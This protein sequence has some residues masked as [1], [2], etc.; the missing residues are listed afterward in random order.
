MKV[1]DTVLIK[2]GSH[3]GMVMRIVD[4]VDMPEGKVSARLDGINMTYPLSW[5]SSLEG[6]SE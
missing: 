4:F 5:L 6:A 3:K 2:R 1:G